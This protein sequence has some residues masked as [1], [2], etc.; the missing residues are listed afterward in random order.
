M[1]A[2][3]K[4][5]EALKE[6]GYHLERRGGNHDI[7]SNDATGAMI[8]IRH[9]FTDADLKVILKEIARYRKGN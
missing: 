9:H 4:A 8:P 2:K 3:K 6:A 1:N 5:L 7:Y